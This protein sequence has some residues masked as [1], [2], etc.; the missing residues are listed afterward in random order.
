MLLIAESTQPK[1]KLS[2]Y[3]ATHTTHISRVHTTIEQNPHMFQTNRK[4]NNYR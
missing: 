1:N 2:D 3:A 4:H